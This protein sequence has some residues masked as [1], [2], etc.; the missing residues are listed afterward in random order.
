ML[1]LVTWGIAR[2]E[3]KNANTRDI[4]QLGKFGLLPYN[5]SRAS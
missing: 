3:K 5:S 1:T 2:E 4:V